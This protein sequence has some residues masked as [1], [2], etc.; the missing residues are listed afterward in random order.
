MPFWRLLLIA[1]GLMILSGALLISG[2]LAY[3][4]KDFAPPEVQP[5]IW[6]GHSLQL[7][8]GEGA[9]GG[10]GLEVR[11][12][13]ASGQA[14]ISSGKIAL[15]TEKYPFLQYQVQGIQPEM[16][17]VF[18]WRRAEERGKVISLPL[19]WKGEGHAMMGLG[20]HP[21][22]Q[23]TIVEFGVAFRKKPAEPVVIKEFTFKPL[24]AVS[25]LA[26]V[27]SEWTTF[28]GWSQRS[29]N[30]IEN[31]TANALVPPTLAAAAWVALSLFFYG[32]W[33]FFRRRHWDWRVVCI[34]FLLGWIVMDLRWQAGLW[35][36]L[37][38]THDR[39]GGK[40]GEEKHLAAE[41]GFLFKFITEIKTHLPPLPQRVFLVTAKPLAEDHYT[42]LRVRYHLL[43]YNVHDY[44][45][46]LPSQDHVQAG[47]YLLILGATPE[48]TFD[49]EQQL[50]Q[51]REGK[52]KGLAAKKIYVASMGTLYQLL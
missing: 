1:L 4:H 19:S 18:F 42:R 52:R 6:Q 5:K 43:P 21:A 40:G 14:I 27:W 35:Q 17:P 45:T 47:D 31:G 15:A 37:Q 22:W 32:L 41:D 10:E 28:E 26:M 46:R 36:Q 7:M 33:G 20:H 49:P 38:Q 39:Y 13:S 9:R 8:A 29:I 2:F 50:L 44:G 3:H 34:A 25:L 11:A 48:F 30:F 24:S 51:G 16:D 12:L 23:G